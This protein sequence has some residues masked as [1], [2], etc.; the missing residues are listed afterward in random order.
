MLEPVST[1][2]QHLFADNAGSSAKAGS[3]GCA[4]CVTN[5]VEAGLDPGPGG[6]HQVVGDV[7]LRQIQNTARVRCIAVR[8]M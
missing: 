8:L 3:H 6:L 7:V 5:D 2:S 4:G 1:R